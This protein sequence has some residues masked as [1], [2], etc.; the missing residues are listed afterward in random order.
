MAR[1][2][3][4]F[5]QA[6][7]KSYR[8][9]KQRQDHVEFTV[10]EFHRALLEGF[11]ANGA[12]L[13]KGAIVYDNLQ[14]SFGL[15]VSGWSTSLS[16]TVNFRFNF[17]LAGNLATHFDVDMKFSETDSGIRV[18]FLKTGDA[19]IGYEKSLNRAALDELIEKI[20]DYL[21]ENI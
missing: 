9:L 13:A 10:D 17:S 20:S 1:T 16:A 5:R 12:M 8:S 19:V 18:Q 2:F 7:A 21:E 3:E 11:D 14:Q 15:D 6:A 4:D